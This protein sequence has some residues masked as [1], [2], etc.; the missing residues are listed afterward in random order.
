[1][2]ANSSKQNESE[3]R[4]IKLSWDDFANIAEKLLNKVKNKKVNVDVIVGNARGGLPLAVYLAHHLGIGTDKFGVMTVQ[5]HTDDS[6]EAQVV[7]PI[8]RGVILPEIKN[9]DIL[10]VED[11][12]G[13]GTASLLCIAQELKK[14]NPRSI[15]AVAMFVGNVSDSE[16]PIIYWNMNND[17]SKRQWVT[18]PWEVALKNNQS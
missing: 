16:V 7:D 3:I 12:V 2:K 17:P 11:T 13:T 4:E 8:L 18:F 15:T 10:V 14:H 9:K 1:M 5:R 6:P